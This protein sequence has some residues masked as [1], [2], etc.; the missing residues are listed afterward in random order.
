MKKEIL[1]SI[2][3][4]I[5]R[6]LD[7]AKNNDIAEFYFELGMWFDGICINYFDIYLD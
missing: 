4:S 1:Q 6:G 5:L 2:G 3:N 7:K